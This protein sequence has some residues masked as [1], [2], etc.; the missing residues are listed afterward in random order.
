MAVIVFTLFGA[1]SHQQ[2]SARNLYFTPSGKLHEHL[3]YVHILLGCL[4]LGIMP[5]PAPAPIL[6]RN[7][8]F[9]EVNHL[10]LAAKNG[11][12][13]ETVHLGRV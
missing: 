4:V 8:F 12:F 3:K 1:L 11:E 7:G 10:P 13:A 5:V 2:N 6:R 9:R